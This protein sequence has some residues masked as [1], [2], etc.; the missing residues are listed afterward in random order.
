MPFMCSIVDM[1]DESSIASQ[2]AQHRSDERNFVDS[3]EMRS[4]VIILCQVLA[5]FLAQQTQDNRPQHLIHVQ[6]A[7][8]V[9][10]YS[11]QIC[12]PRL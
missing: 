2:C 5:L 12:R 11:Y 8:Q 1:S 6:L 10:L 7:D 3:G 4:G 9:S